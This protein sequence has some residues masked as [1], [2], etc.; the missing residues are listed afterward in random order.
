MGV[1]ER[2]DEC[3]RIEVHCYIGD[4]GRGMKIQMN[5]P[6]PQAF[7]IGSCAWR[8]NIRRGDFCLSFRGRRD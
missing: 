4:E 7:G 5:L 3:R 6:E 8:G 2:L 1:L